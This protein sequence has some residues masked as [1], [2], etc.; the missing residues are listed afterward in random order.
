MGWEF[1]AFRCGFAELLRL[2][3]Y[4]HCAWWYTLHDQSGI[5]YYTFVHPILPCKL[6]G[7]T[8]I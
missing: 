1:G 6:V 3:N 4:L 8:E 5:N 7:V 2:F